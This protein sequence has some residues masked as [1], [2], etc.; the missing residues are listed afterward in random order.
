GGLFVLEREARGVGVCGR[1]V[2][3]EPHQDGQVPRA[4]QQ[5]VGG[6]D[7]QLQPLSMPRQQG[8]EGYAIRCP[9]LRGPLE[10]GRCCPADASPIFASSRA[11]LAKLP[12]FHIS[13]M[14]ND[15]SRLSLLKASS[16]KR[17]V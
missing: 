10:G 13:L 11:P 8:S 14:R 1:L 12:P 9:S 4:I 2:G 5:E 17:W 6:E 16:T 7:F 15:V 3:V